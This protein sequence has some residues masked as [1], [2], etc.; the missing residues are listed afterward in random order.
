MDFSWIHPT[1]LAIMMMIIG[2]GFF[3]FF[4]GFAKEIVSIITWLAAITAG[5]VLTPHL[6]TKLL[7][8]VPNFEYAEWIIGFLV[9]L[10]VLVF[11]TFICN[12]IRKR[13]KLD[14]YPSINRSLG[15]LYGILKGFLIIGFC[16]ITIK[17]F[18]NGQ[19]YPDWI[20]NSKSFPLIE[21]S[22]NLA[23]TPLPKN[24]KNA[25]E[26]LN[27]DVQNRPQSSRFESLN[28]PSIRTNKKD[29]DKGY[30]SEQ[31]KLMDNRIKGLK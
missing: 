1:D 23:L 4:R 21:K 12:R 30:S 29:G 27:L 15:F 3:S 17:W 26:K 25:F 18:L 2:S 10:F 22:V 16:F 5:I 6:T 31:R 24:I 28:L 9:G 11:L 8:F 19:K 14:E 7:D 20:S 13:A